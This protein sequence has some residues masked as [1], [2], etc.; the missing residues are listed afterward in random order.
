LVCSPGSKVFIKLLVVMFLA[1]M[2]LV[3]LHHW[4]NNHHKVSSLKRNIK[5]NNHY[6]WI[7]SNLWEIKCKNVVRFVKW[8]KEDKNRNSS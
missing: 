6:K 7:L 3:L 5:D 4:K 8:S 2:I 1:S